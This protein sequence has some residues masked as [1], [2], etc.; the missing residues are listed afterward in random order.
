MQTSLNI[1]IGKILTTA[2]K[3][4]ASNIH[5]A[6]SAYPALRIDE[7]LIELEDEQMI[8]KDFIEKLTEDWLDA[9][10]K[11]ELEKKKEVV[12]VKVVAK[13]FRV[14]VSFFFQKNVL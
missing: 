13:R 11:Q 8:T 5:L 12:V 4:K 10:Q 9:E 1:V 2:A 3:R 6:V 14:R 7:E